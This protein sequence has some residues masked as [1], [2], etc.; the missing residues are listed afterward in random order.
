MLTADQERF[1]SFRKIP[2]IPLS[3]TSMKSL[4][5]GEKEDLPLP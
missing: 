4:Y 5:R 1:E 3:N 2:V